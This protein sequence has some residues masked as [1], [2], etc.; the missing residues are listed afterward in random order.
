MQA[1]ITYNKVG[2]FEFNPAQGVIFLF[3][4]YTANS[5]EYDDPDFFRQKL[6]DDMRKFHSGLHNKNKINI[7]SMVLGPYTR[8]ILFEEQ[9][10]AGDMVI[11]DNNSSKPKI[12][13]NKRY[14]NKEDDSL[15][16]KRIGSF[17]V[18]T[19]DFDIEGFGGKIITDTC[20]YI[21]SSINTTNIILI[22]VIVM[23]AMYLFMKIGR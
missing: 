17:I 20:H 23:I 2:G 9:N 14:I 6:L 1:D 7:R 10:Y 12:F 22:I 3:C 18:T 15:I 8:A 21:C 19:S 5:L 13:E 16:D 4:D 11:Y